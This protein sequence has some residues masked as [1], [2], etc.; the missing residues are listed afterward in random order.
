[1]K[2]T[3][4]KEGCCHPTELRSGA[5]SQ[6]SG[7]SPENQGGKGRGKHSA[8]SDSSTLLYKWDMKGSQL[9]IFSVFL[10][11]RDRPLFCK[12]A[13]HCLGS[14]HG[15]VDPFS[16]YLKKVSFLHCAIIL[17]IWALYVAWP[18]RAGSWAPWLYRDCEAFS[19]SPG[20][21]L[22]KWRLFHS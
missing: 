22:L 14:K 5:V 13:E 9:Q 4:G 11:K 6:V 16:K 20:T 17:L 18:A 15:I 2:H 12:G 10:P 3:L 7:W 1:M 8:C 21:A 19:V